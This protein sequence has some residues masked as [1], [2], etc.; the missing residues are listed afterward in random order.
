MNSTVHGRLV[1][2]VLTLVVVFL[3]RQAAAE[4]WP[5]WRGPRGDGTSHE[6]GIA[7]SWNGT[8]GQNVAWKVP[9]PG[10]GHASP[11]VWRDRLFLV[12]CLEESLDRVLLCFN[13]E[14]GTLRWQ[15]TVVH[16]PLEG[17]HV[18]NSYASS[19]PATDGEQIYTAFL[20]RDQVLVSAYD[21]DGREKW[22]ARPGVFSSRHGFCSCPVLYEDLVIINGDHDGESYLAALDRTDGSI[23]WKVP[24]PNQTRSYVTPILR[25][26][27][28]RTQLI[29]SGTKC[30]TSYDPTDGRLHWIIDG[31][32]EQFVAS[33]VDNG[34]LLFLTAGFPEHHMLAIRPDGS[35]NVT[36]THV[37]WRTTEGA[38]YVPS[39]IAAGDYFLVVSD[40]GIAS[41]FEASTGE[42]KW[43]A[44]LPGGHSASL[45]SAGGLVYFTSDS[46]ITTVVHPGEKYEKV[47]E[48]PLG[49]RSFASPA[50]SNGTLYIRGER[51]LFAIRA[52]RP[53]GN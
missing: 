32:T 33:L 18:L 7:V 11:V 21:L 31:P 3:A 22:T 8:T 5:G 12:A 30:V 46:G 50:I 10:V 20:D 51:Q 25:S 13:T 28:G 17:K 16:S 37:V 2:L 40:E 27:A 38:S 15:R 23:R 34:D 45:V 44:R 53:Q 43:R 9:V 14:D 35:G 6:S 41:E 4:D 19:T 52:G 39:P 48:N 49:E 29:L 24:R 42:R 36:D 26:L 47:A 1:R